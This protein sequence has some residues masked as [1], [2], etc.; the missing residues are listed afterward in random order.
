MLKVE[1]ATVDDAIYRIVAF[2][3]LADEAEVLE[4]GDVISCQGSLQLEF[5]QGKN[6]HSALMG[7]YVI[8]GQI[9][10]LRKRR[11]NR[12]PIMAATR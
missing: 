5:S 4:A 7:V 8:A 9:T 6:G 1:S 12:M 3:G 2:D 11:P 10:P